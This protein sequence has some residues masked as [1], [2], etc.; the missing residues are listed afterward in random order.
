MSSEKE[1]KPGVSL[2]QQIAQSI[3]QDI[4]QQGLA[5]HTRISSEAEFTRQYGVSHNTINKA[6]ELLVHQ[7]VLYRR[8]PQGTFVAAQGEPVQAVQAK[9]GSEPQKSVPRIGLIIPYMADSFSNTIVLG[10]EMEARTAGFRLDFAYSENDWAMERYHLKQFLQDGVAG[11]VLFPGDHPIAIQ[12]GRFVSTEH[13]ERIEMLHELQQQQM[14]FVLLDR[15]IPEVVCNHVVSDDFTAGYAAT[16]HLIS[17]GHQRIGY[18][19]I[20]PEMTSS[21]NRYLG[22]LRCLADNGLSSDQNLILQTLHQELPD[23]SLSRTLDPVDRARV[24]EY[25]QQEQRPD[26]LLAMNDYVA[27]QVLQAAQE[28]NLRIPQALALVCCGGVDIGEFTRV[29]LTSILQPGAELGR[30]ST[31]ILLNLITQRTSKVHQVVLPVN[32][33]IR[34]SCGA[35]ERPIINERAIARA[36]PAL[37]EDSGQTR[38]L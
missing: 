18:I 32:L 8:R 11:I 33:I 29:P 14:P 16:Q 4:V 6:L 23:L 5:P 36:L 24:V 3:Q 9:R 13:K 2:H 35:N 20:I 37:H 30:Q 21:A 28:I 17:Q 19:S 10:V 12:N 7:G 15:Y 1:R 26:A 25:L 38:V 31:R 34:Q 22:Y 27:L